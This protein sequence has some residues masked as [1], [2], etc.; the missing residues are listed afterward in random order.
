MDVG[1]GGAR[2]FW[3]RLDT[4]LAPA[5]IVRRMAGSPGR[6]AAKSHRGPR[7]RRACPPDPHIRNSQLHAV[8]RCVA[9]RLRHRYLCARCD[10]DLKQ[11]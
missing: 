2:E 10:T 11:P 4:S 8:A 9:L 7:E 1:G 5:P 3:R 6:A